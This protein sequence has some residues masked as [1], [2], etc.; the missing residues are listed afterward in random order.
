LQAVDQSGARSVARSGPV[1][2]EIG[3]SRELSRQRVKKKATLRFSALPLCLPRCPWACRSAPVPVA[4]PLCLPLCRCTRQARRRMGA[5]LWHATPPRQTLD[6]SRH[7]HSVPGPLGRAVN[8]SRGRLGFP[9]IGV[10][11]LAFAP[12]RSTP[13]TRRSQPSNAMTAACSGLRGG[14]RG[15]EGLR[16]GGARAP[17]AQRGYAEGARGRRLH[18]GATRRGREAGGG[19]STHR[20]V[21]PGVPAHGRSAF[22]VARGGLCKSR[23]R[24]AHGGCPLQCSRVHASCPD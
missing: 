5:R 16:P 20:R 18:R 15:P 13:S 2:S 7:A 8:P 3:N 19:Y 6:L 22:G 10:F 12:A 23:R 21:Q 17:A 11:S 9:G 24:E 14:A 1:S 4:R